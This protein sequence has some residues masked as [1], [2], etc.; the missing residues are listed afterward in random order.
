MSKPLE[1][2]ALIGDCETAALVSHDGSIDWLCWPRF[3]SGACFAALLGTRM[4]G[5]WLL[6][7]RDPE[8][9]ITRRYRSKSLVLETRIETRGGAAVV[10]DF[11]PPRGKNADVVRIV[12]GVRGHVEMD[13]ELILRFDY[14]STVPWVN[15]LP[16]GTFRAIA[17]PDMVV[18]RTPVELHGKDLTTVAQFVVKK[19]D[20]VPFVMTHGPSHLPAPKKIDPEQALRETEAFWQDWVAQSRVRGKWAGAV[21][22]SLITL[23][24]LTYAPTGGLVA[25]PTT[26]LPEHLGGVRNWDY[27][28]CWL[29]D[30]TIT[31]LALMN[32]GYYDEARAWRNWL[33]RAGAGSPS[34]L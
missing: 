16:D 9:R 11:M 19:G 17:G 22:R 28:F 12:R 25:A 29:R 2:Y 5:R 7:A 31:L 33:L 3:D 14:G 30:A 13:T 27:R 20:S 4:H 18:V 15:R 1:S 24:A 6:A 32:A 21:T 8:A 10:I 34:Q 23:K 26:S